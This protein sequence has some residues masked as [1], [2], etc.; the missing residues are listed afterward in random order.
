MATSCLSEYAL[1]P[2]ED[3]ALRE[4]LLRSLRERRHEWALSRVGNDTFLN[5]AAGLWI[6]VIERFDGSHSLSIFRSRAEADGSSRQVARVE[7]RGP[8]RS[9]LGY[10]RPAMP[11]YPVVREL[12]A[13]R[14]E[15]LRPD[16]AAAVEDL[17]RPRETRWRAVAAAAE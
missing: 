6:M 7:A 15:Q 1:T 16:V 3:A 4:S 14:H 12:H 11:W 2:E 10:R 8:G 9:F 17:E 5:D 13:L